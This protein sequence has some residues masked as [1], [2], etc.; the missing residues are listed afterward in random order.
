VIV[1]ALLEEALAV[2][3]NHSIQAALILVLRVEP[4]EEIGG[5]IAALGL[6][7]GREVFGPLENILVVRKMVGCNL[8][9]GTNGSTDH[10]NFFLNARSAKEIYNQPTIN[11][12]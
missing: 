7:R 11:V 4:A 1:D 3:F 6:D 8:G 2:E 10:V 9:S 5:A 12:E